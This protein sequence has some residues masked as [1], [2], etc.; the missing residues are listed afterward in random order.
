ME[1]PTIP[2]KF[3]IPPLPAGYLRRPR[4]DRLWEQR[5]H[6]RL[7]LVTAGAGYG[8]SSF[9]AGR[10]REEA[11]F[12][13]YRLDEGD[14]HL[15]SFV[16]H[17]RHLLGTP[18]PRLDPEEVRCDPAVARRALASAIA[19]L[20]ARG[21]TV[22]VLD[23]AHLFQTA[24]EVLGFLGSL[25][26]CLP[27]TATLVLSSR[28]PL[29]VG[30]IRALVEG[31]AATIDAR[32]LEFRADEVGALFALRLGVTPSAQQCRRILTATEGWAAGLEILFQA[33]DSP[34][35]AAVDAAL[36]RVQ[37]AGSGWFDYF[38]E[39]VIGRLD[40]S[41]ADFLRRSSVFSRIDPA[42][43]DRV[44]G[45]EDSRE[46]LERLVRRNLFTL[47]EGAAGENYRYHL[48][49]RSCLRTALSHA[50]PAVAQ[51]RLRRNAAQ[52]LLRAG[53]VADA[54]ELFSDAGDS[55][56]ALRL[57]ERQ[58]E[59]LLGAG[60]YEAVAKAL[61][62][63]PAAR[64]RR[65]P[66]ALFVQARLLD[67]HGHWGEAES[68]FRRL[69]RM[70]T[71]IARRV[72]LYSILG[73]IASRRGE[74]TRALTMS[75]AGLQ[76][77][78]AR[79][80]STQGRLLMTIGISACELGRIDEG[81]VHL[82][83][84]RAVFVRHGDA[85]GEAYVD[86]ITAANVHLPRGDFTQ[87]Q[88]T[89]RRALARFR[90][91][92]VPRRICVCRAVLSW[93][94]VL[95]GDVRD[96]R[97]GALEVRRLAE[98]LGLR[99]Q[100][101]SALY[102]L[103]YCSYLEGDLAGAR[104][105][106][107]ESSRIGDLLGESDARIL[108]RL[109]QAE[110]LLAAG[111][112][113]GAQSLAEAAL[114]IARRMKDPLQQAQ[115]RVVLGR[116]AAPEDLSA[117]GALWRSAERTF[118][119]IGA[120]FDLHRVMLLRLSQ[121]ELRP[122]EHRRLLAE[123]MAGAARRGHD[124]LFLLMEPARAARVLSEALRDDTGQEYAAGLLARLGAG[125]VKEIQP[126]TEDQ[127]DVVRTR[128]VE[129]LAQIGG[130]RARG[131]L[132]RVARHEVGRPSAQRAQEELA[133]TP[134]QPLH[135]ETLG[136]FRV[137]IGEVP[138]PDERWR[139]ARARRLFQYLLVRRF[140]WV[141]RDQIVE[142]LWPE[143]D[144]EKARGN[145][146][147]S[148]YY[149]RRALEPD[150]KDLR[151]SRYV[152]SAEDTYRLEPGE[153]HTCDLV[154]FEESIREADRV[155]AARRE[156]MAEPLYQR[157]LDLYKGEFLAESPYEEFAAGEREHLRDLF[158]HASTKLV[159]LYVSSRRWAQCLPI[160]R[161][162]LKEDPYHEELSYHLIRALISLGHRRKAVEAYREL[163][164]RMTG[165]LNLVPSARMQALVEMIRAMP[166]ARR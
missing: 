61:Q 115:C 41:T 29:G 15:A 130:P 6:K 27:A 7:L 108:P 121:E 72:E 132:A 162:G 149:L 153:G 3:R 43:C 159:E 147:Q 129:L 46:I 9:L 114:E 97:E 79:S 148:V 39:E 161:L 134:I 55:E 117:A 144:P 77:R 138:V 143:V 25:I 156:R 135:I 51:Q 104:D 73:Q 133:R 24:A 86:Y 110:C 13:W 140:R 75:R 59:T 57:I 36:E 18:D 112:R 81:E 65:S 123:L 109:L 165:E 126:L 88:E 32:D 93:V 44:L 113:Q 56:N 71:G 87:G 92:G 102:V 85:A 23:D 74:Y 37:S 155:A 54:L 136:S 91:L 42:I 10:A 101:A 19:A 154:D 164:Q 84:A 120:S 166:R 103:G 5:C 22:L 58:G 96:A 122:A 40:E 31:R 94:T 17:L 119:L 160:C 30:A 2:E 66:Q 111:K 98:A 11:P 107:Q 139:S 38:A 52:A 70:R 124:S 141:N 47:R 90:T 28:E 35:P 49:F 95:A 64:L 63:V 116:V 68:L 20:R 106:L 21:R 99:Q 53:E 137:R 128:A 152:R 1:G 14:V 105:Q 67:Y 33:L 62:A 100:E 118:R 8:K 145:L 80:A 50:L 26:P 69:L 78:G 146:W 158:L 12:L 131:L 83:K 127:S 82:K 48:L 89:A 163:E 142:A 157:A 45:R 16:A 34:S 151:A 125:A 4:L 76:E 150:L 60:R